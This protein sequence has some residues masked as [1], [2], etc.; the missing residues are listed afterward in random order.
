MIT[1]YEAPEHVPA[2]LRLFLAGGIT[3]CP[4]WQPE[5]IERLEHMDELTIYNPRREN[6]PIDDSDAAE[7]QIK[8]EHEMLHRADLISFWFPCET[9]CPI[10]LYELGYW[11]D[12]DWDTKI[13]VGIHPEYDRKQDVFIQ[14]ELN[15]AWGIPV[16]EGFD[17]FVARVE[18]TILEMQNDA[19]S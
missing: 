3:A 5:M 10:T 17:N 7:E 2:P 18:D 14:T 11:T 8:W 9:L 6:F 15:A 19:A 1:V 16:E 13:V 12:H 4:Q